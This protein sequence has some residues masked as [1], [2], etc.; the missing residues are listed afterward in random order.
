MNAISNQPRNLTREIADYAVSTSFEQLPAEV[1]ERARVLIIDEIASSCF[2]ARSLGGALAAQYVTSLGGHSQC[3]L[4]GTALKAPA[5]L[6]ALANGTAGHGE[7]VD[8]AHVAGGHPGAT[9]VAAALAIAEARGSNGKE[10]LNA[11][12]LGYDVGVRVLESCGDVYEVRD[13]LHLHSDFLYSLGAATAGSRLL[14]LD[15]DAHAHALALATFQ[16]NGLSALFQED[17][18]ISKSLSNG[19][20]ASA[21]VTA[22]LMAATG[23]E[24]TKDVFGGRHGVLD[25]WG[26]EGGEAA[27][28]R[29]LGVR[30]AVMEAN[31]KMIN[32][33]YPIHSPVEA[34]VTLLRT[35]SLVVDEIDEVIIGMP[36][37]ALRVVDNRAMHNICAQDMV[38]VALVYGGIGIRELPFPGVLS[39]TAYRRLRDRVRVEVDAELQASQPNGR[40]SRVTIHTSDGAVYTQTVLAPRGHSSRGGLTWDDLREKW[41]DG[42]PE[43]DIDRIISMGKQLD[44]LDDIR[45][46]LDAFVS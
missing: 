30:Y 2:G 33:G 28:T 34:A 22:A 29:D 9:I 3:S 8:G 35:H 10:L 12:V 26:T 20:Y 5:P 4:L 42:M 11:I 1:V 6:A 25:A 43:R 17:R 31:F 44:Q 18:H 7:E 14:R 24:G 27:L 41:T 23:F 40:G 32:A 46:L 16:A 39:N 37:N 36:D 45:P 19:Q 38:S 21:G 15:A 13:R